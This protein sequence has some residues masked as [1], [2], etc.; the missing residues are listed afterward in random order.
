MKNTERLKKC[1]FTS[2]LAALSIV[3]Y[4]LGP[5]FPLPNLFPSFLEL[6]FSLLPI[7]LACFIC[8]NKY[9]FIVV[10]IRFII[11][12]CFGTST[13]GIG[14]T[15]DLI[16]GLVVVGTIFL[17]NKIFKDKCHYVP[18]FIFVILGVVIGG[19]LS[20]VFALPMY[21]K[22]MGFTKETFVNMLSS[23]YKNCTI[24]NFLFYYFV[25]AIIP[26]N[27]LLG[28]ILSLISYLVWIPLSKAN[29]KF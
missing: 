8:G 22:V 28:S 16:I 5:K 15:A 12:L 18:T 19:I 9:G 3:L 1:I 2:I 21:I 17:A 25:C 14:E 6:N 4:V 27:L 7:I 29:I 23:I 24:D 20:N 10:L 26:F 11:K 13:A